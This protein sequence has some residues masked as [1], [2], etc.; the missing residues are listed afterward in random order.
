MIAYAEVKR[1]EKTEFGQV[2]T[3]GT[4]E[5]LP[6]GDRRAILFVDIDGINP[7]PQQGWYY[8]KSTELFSETKPSGAVI[9]KPAL[10]AAQFWMA[11]FTPNERAGVWALCNGESVPGVTI[12][13]RARYRLAA[14]KDISVSGDPV[15][16]HAA[17]TRAVVNGLETAGLLGAGRAAEILA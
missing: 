11:R 15:K 12:N 13:Q 17:E 2:R 14:F 9:P 7:A 5:S 8:D 4:A 6:G 1:F 16:L 10:T 3:I